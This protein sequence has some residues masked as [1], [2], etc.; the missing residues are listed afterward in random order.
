LALGFFLGVLTAALVG[1]LSAAA[2]TDEQAAL[3]ADRNFNSAAARN[4][5]AAAGELLDV[6]FEWTDANGKT[7]SKTEALQNLNVLA[8]D[9]NGDTDVKT[10]PYGQIEVITGTHRG[11]RFMRIWVNRSAGW[12]AFALLDTAIAGGTAPF[13]N[14]ASGAGGGAADCENPCRTIPYKPTTA[15][16]KAIVAILQRLKMDE[17]HPN[18]DDW[19]RYVL[20]GVNYVTSAASLSKADRVAR[21]A[22][23]KQSGAAIVPGDPVIAMRISDFGDAAIMFTRNAP[24]RGGKPYYSLRV[25]TFRDGRWQLANSQQTVIASAPEVPAVISQK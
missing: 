17:W 22:Q 10:Y 16:D 3:Q 5:K 19:A 18:P 11:A 12:R 25:W 20:D 9:N 1:G 7:R 13:S 2:A 15:A 4:D 14:T 24:Y 21:L 8:A 23:Q 6:Q